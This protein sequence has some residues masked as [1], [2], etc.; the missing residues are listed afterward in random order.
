LFL[1]TRLSVHPPHQICLVAN[2]SSQVYSMNDPDLQNGIDILESTWY[3]LAI[4]I[5]DLAIRTYNL[6]KEQAQALKEVYLKQNHY[7]VEL[8]T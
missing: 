4:S 1:T 6:S 5:V 3:L 8:Q 7:Y 2:P